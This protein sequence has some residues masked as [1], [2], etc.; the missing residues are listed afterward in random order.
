MVFTMLRAMALMIALVS[1]AMVAGSGC[2]ASPES[3][4]SGSPIFYGGECHSQNALGPKIPCRQ[5]QVK[6]L[7]ETATTW[8]ACC[9]DDRNSQT[10][11]L[12]FARGEGQV[13]EYWICPPSKDFQR[14]A[15][16]RTASK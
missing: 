6:V 14:T 3:C 1:L 13:R 8:S 5:G 9:Q 11:C 4:G 7:K 2:A 15:C 12:E 10:H 16:N